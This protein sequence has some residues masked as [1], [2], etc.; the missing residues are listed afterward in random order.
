MRFYNELAPWWPVLSPPAEYEEEALQYIAMIRGAAGSEV[1]EVLELGSGGGSNALHMKAAFALTLV[2]PAGG[3]REVSR[4]L[5]PE[6]AHLPGDMRTVRLGRTFDAVFVHDAIAYMATE[7]DLRAAL[8]TVAAH[9]APGGVAVVA[10]DETTETFAP[11]AHVSTGADP[12]T[13]RAACLVEWTPDAPPGAT[14]YES[15]YGFM[16]READG[17]VHSIHEPHRFG[18]FPRA[19]WLALFR[20]AGLEA[21]LATRICEGEPYDTFVAV[22][23]APAAPAPAATTPAAEPAE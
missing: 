20:E 9:L 23:V 22:R 16:L 4:A 18:V 13:G 15:H 17:T 21:R 8:E 7:A 1:R 11:G 10:P 5:N 19:T 6:C 3:M 2:E 14:A 12:A